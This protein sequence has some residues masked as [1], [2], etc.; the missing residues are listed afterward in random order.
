MLF[1]DNVIMYVENS[2]ESTNIRINKW[3]WYDLSTQVYYRKKCFYMPAKPNRKFN[4]ERIKI[5]MI[6]W[7]L[8]M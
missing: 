5:A 3:I 4:L 2:K 1:V 6:K 8:Y 7:A